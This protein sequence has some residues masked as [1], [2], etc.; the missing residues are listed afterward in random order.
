MPS[1]AS[2]DRAGAGPERV[3]I[4]FRYVECR[5]SAVASTGFQEYSNGEMVLEISHGPGNAGIGALGLSWLVVPL[6]SAAAEDVEAEPPPKT[7]TH[8]SAA[9]PAVGPAGR[10]GPS[11]EGLTRAEWS[12]RFAEAEAEVE[13]AQESLDESLD[14]LSEL[15]GKTGNWKVAAPGVQV[16]PQ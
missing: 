8:G 14:K 16:C 7:V 9:H 13:T 11:V 4:V 1:G 2:G 10:I 5:W 12:S 15:V 6:L 3:L